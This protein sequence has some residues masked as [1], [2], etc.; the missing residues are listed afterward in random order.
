M[1]F[2]L[3]P[4]INVSEIDLTTVVPAVSTTTGAI[5]GVFAWGPVNEPVL[6]SSEVDLVKRFGKPTA[7]STWKNTETFFTAADFLAYGNSL[8]VVRVS[9]GNTADPTGVGSTAANIGFKAKHPGSIGNSLRIIATDKN[10]YANANNTL[11]SVVTGVPST[12]SAHVVVV[13]IDGKFS[14]VANSVIEVFED[15]SLVS[16]AKKED[17][18]N[19][20]ITDVINTYSNYIKL[21]LAGVPNANTSYLVNTQFVEDF[22]NGTDDLDED[23]IAIG[24][25][26]T[27]YDYFANPEEIDV[28]LI[29]Q[30]VARGTNDVELA[31]YITQIAEA[32][33]D[34]MAFI[35]PASGDVVGVTAS[36]ALTNVSNFAKALAELK[37]SSYAVVDSGYKY[38]Y[39]RYN[40]KYVYTPLN[41]DIAGLCARTDNTRDPW[42]SPAGYN[43]GGIKNIIKLAYN[44]GK[45]D[46]DAL[47][48]LSV[49]PVV[50]QTGQ[51]T[52][53]FGDKTFM[54]KP[55]AFDRI[56]VRRL[57]IVLEKAISRA[58]KSTLF[59]FNDEFTRAQFKNLVEPFLR[60]VQGRSGIYDYR[61]VCD[62]TNNTPEIIDRN[63]F[64]GD[65][66]I[67]PARAINFIQLNF[68]AVRTGVEFN[69]IIGQR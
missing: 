62:E 38:R 47:Y 9:S 7:N 29:M 51:G 6:V 11:K 17:G 20:Y 19:N 63:E 49:N 16:G 44:P 66:Y 37:T 32:R 65:I 14:G 1:A 4:G 69:E 41:G 35:S 42:F 24:T 15:V 46:R 48:K 22:A 43:R 58:S 67:K 26:K 25:L 31:Q 56:N 18:T 57:F 27:G 10:Q 61:V 5:A 60:D 13:D 21:E 55:S 39:D 52:V 12:N 54:S 59:E 28:S 3:S 45:A 68:V 8:Y 2:Q 33:M 64:V 23:D 30:G 36:A 40:D 34:A 53:L 50:T